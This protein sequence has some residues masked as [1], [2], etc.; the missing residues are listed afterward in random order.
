MQKLKEL[1]LMDTAET[2]LREKNEPLDIYELFDLVCKVQ[3]VEDARKSDL[4]SHFYS[5]ITISAKF[6]YVGDN[7]WD[8][9]EK[10]KVELWEKDGS[11]YKEY[12]EFKMPERPVEAAPKKAKPVEVPVVEAKPIPVV[13]EE[14]IELDDDFF[15]EVSEEEPAEEPVKEPKKEV[16]EEPVVEPVAKDEPEYEEE[17]EEVFDDLEEDDFDEEKYNEYMDTYEDRYDE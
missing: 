5:D 2:I 11:F 7:Q 6:V 17:Y 4:V 1:S 14:P 13:E 8:L 3:E 16:G 10:Q 9:K 12:T 15:A